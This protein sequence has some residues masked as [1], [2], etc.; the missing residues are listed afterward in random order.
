VGNVL[1]PVSG[2]II[3]VEDAHSDAS[4]SDEAKTELR[5]RSGPR[6]P[7]PHLQR[8]DTSSERFDGNT[9]LA[10]GTLPPPLLE[11]INFEEAITEVNTPAPRA[12]QRPSTLS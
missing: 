7:R 2:T 10:E 9:R 1:S 3:V 5:R 4:A 11:E 6:F 12:F 8:L